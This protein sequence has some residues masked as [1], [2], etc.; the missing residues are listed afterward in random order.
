M[1]VAKK[2]KLRLVGRGAKAEVKAKPKPKVQRKAIWSRQKDRGWSQ[3]ERE[4]FKALDHALDEIYQHACDVLKWTWGQ[5][6]SEA[7]L[8]DTTVVNL[9]E[10]ITKWPRFYTVFKLAKAVGFK[11]ALKGTGGRK[12]V[13]LRK[14][15]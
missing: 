3:L 4:Y 2:N 12:T 13:V 14:A 11:L 5:L 9:G 1:P 10:R 7:D 6:A 8:S 15:S